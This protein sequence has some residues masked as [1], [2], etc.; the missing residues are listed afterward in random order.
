MRGV[1][2]AVVTLAGAVAINNFG[3]QNTT[4]GGGGLGSPVPEM[5]WFG[6]DLGP[7]AGFRGIDGNQP[8]P[9]FG[10]VVLICVVLACVGVGYLRRGKLG[11]QMLAVRSNERAAAAPRSTRGPSSCT[12]SSSR[13]SSPAWPGACTRT[14]SAR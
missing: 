5:N 1:S 8:S 4:W 9:V 6:L 10:W 7:N 14:T 13:R 2:L 3:F 12:R 11:Q